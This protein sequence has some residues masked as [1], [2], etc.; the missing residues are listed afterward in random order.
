MD[1]MFTR[2]RDRVRDLYRK[3]GDD[4]SRSVAI[5]LT[6]LCT[7]AFVSFV[8][9]G[10]VGAF[11]KSHSTTTNTPASSAQATIAPAKGA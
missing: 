4:L 8:M 9:A 11:E 1:R 3:N 5:V 6:V 2:V 7:L 10:V